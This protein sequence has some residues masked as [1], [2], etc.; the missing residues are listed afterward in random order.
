MYV[1]KHL[2]SLGRAGTLALL[3]CVI[4]SVRESWCARDDTTQSRGCR[5]SQ[6]AI[7]GRRRR[8][9]VLLLVVVVVV[10]GRRVT[11]FCGRRATVT[12]MATLGAKSTFTYP[13]LDTLYHIICTNLPHMHERRACKSLETGGPAAADLTY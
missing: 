12:L 5:A 9:S 2:V 4:E 11:L 1:C 8:R 3:W 7:K 6:P 13:A 10:R